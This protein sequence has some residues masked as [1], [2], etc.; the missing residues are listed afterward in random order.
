MHLATARNWVHMMVLS[1]RLYVCLVQI[2]TC[3]Q[4]ELGRIFIQKVFFY[5][6][7]G[8]FGV[9]FCWRDFELI[10]VMIRF[11]LIACSVCQLQTKLHFILFW[12]FRKLIC[13][14]SN[15]SVLYSY[16]D[17][18]IESHFWVMKVLTLI[19]FSRLCN[20]LSTA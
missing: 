18:A 6:Q 9:C 8:W 20:S 14:S 1:F 10:T 3:D 7:M 17:P 16:V 11:D 19:F 5:P 12:I 15:V 2:I 4:F 13:I